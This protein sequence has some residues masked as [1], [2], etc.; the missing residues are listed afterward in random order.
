MNLKRHLREEEKDEDEDEDDVVQGRVIYI[1]YS[2]YIND[3]H[4]FH[5]YVIIE[6]NYNIG[7]TITI[8]QIVLRKKA[9]E[10]IHL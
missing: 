8:L 10:T 9:L 2:D 4:V 3:I 1:I 5:H 6:W 7:V